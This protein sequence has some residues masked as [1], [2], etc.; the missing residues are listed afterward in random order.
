MDWSNR[1]SPNPCA[2]SPTRNGGSLAR[3]ARDD[4]TRSINRQRCAIVIPPTRDYRPCFNSGCPSRYD[5]GSASGSTITPVSGRHIFG[6][7]NA[8]SRDKTRANGRFGQLS[9]GCFYSSP[10]C[11]SRH[12]NRPG[13]CPDRGPLCDPSGCILVKSGAAICAPCHAST[14]DRLTNG[15][16]CTTN[17]RFTTIGCSNPQPPTPSP[18]P[19]PKP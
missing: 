10:D 11:L 2:P 13:Y 14:C 15:C 5:S 18:Q 12:P 19:P 8:N 16:T 6:R 17:G 1:S 9:A 7:H 3:A 4:H